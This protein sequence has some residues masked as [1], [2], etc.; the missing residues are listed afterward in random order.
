MTF[1]NNFGK[2]LVL[3]MRNNLMKNMKKLIILLLPFGQMLFGHGQHGY[4]DY[5]TDFQQGSEHTHTHH[6]EGDFTDSDNDG[7]TDVAEVKYGYNPNSASSFPLIDFVAESD[8][9]DTSTPVSNYGFANLRVH[10]TDG[11]IELT[12]NDVDDSYS[13]S[14]FSL[15]LFAGDKE[16]YYGGHGWDYA[17]VNY[18]LFGLNGTETLNGFL[19]ESNPSNGAYV[20]THTNFEIDLNDYP[21][22]ATKF[23]DPSNKITFK[24]VNFTTEQTNKYTD[25]MRRVIPILNDVL[26]VPSENF[27]CE[28]IMQSDEGNS[29]VTMNHGREIYLDA[30]WNPRLLVHEMVHMWEGKLGFSWS[31]FNR[32]Y[33]DDLSAFAEVAEG[34]A[35]RVLHDYIMAY[36]EHYVS[37][38]IANG[39]P[40]NNWSSD[41]WTYDLYKHKR[42]TGGGA[43]WT[44][45]LRSVNHRYSISAM[46]MQIILVQDP[47][48]IKNMRK[49]LFD[50]V[51]ADNHILSREE[52]VNLW[53]SNIE[54]INGID[55]ADY[56]NA[57]PVFN[58][59]KL[60]QGFYPVVNIISPAEVDIFSSYVTDGMFWWSYVVPDNSVEVQY[61]SIPISSLNVPSWVKY[62]YN[63]YDGYYYVDMNDIPFTFSI[64]NIKNEVLSAVDL[65]SSNGYQ[66]EGIIPDH[67]GEIRVTDQ[68]EVAPESFTQGLYKYNVTYTEVIKHTNEG[69]EDFYFMG[70]KDMPQSEGEMVLMFGVDSM[71]AEK[72]KV[73]GENLSVELEVVNGCA[74]LKTSDIPLNK[75]MMLTLSV[76]SLDETHV[77]KRALVHAGNSWG[78]YRQQFLIIDRDFDGVED[79]YDNSVSETDITNKYN[80][81]KD[82]HT[83]GGG[84][85]GGGDNG[86]G[87]DSNNGED[88]DFLLL[89]DWDTAELVG[90]N[91]KHLDWFGYFY[92]S[93]INPKWMYHVEL[94]WLYVP[95]DSFDSIW[96]YSEKFG[97]IWTTSEFFPFVYIRDKGWVYFNFDQGKYYDFTKKQYVTLQ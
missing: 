32:E 54:T 35:Y 36:P 79:L 4:A 64:K 15:A 86:G 71:F 56:L 30:N 48:F 38:D 59:K 49:D 72:V 93:A 89:N 78:E 92:Q 10:Q 23:G 26:G 7:M 83:N 95:G 75:E 11:G 42:F 63:P 70:E 76:S 57:M 39:G 88:D 41:A 60:D 58:G 77:Y 20:N 8:G 91:W 14:R 46:L 31:G 45:D 97:W 51:N 82:K 9:E 13:W 52:I 43:Y 81:Y 24:F 87:D 27:T 65:R 68:Y 2:V 67:L 61:G 55:T 80:A 29:W 47:D 12:W 96:M 5:G 1:Y 22:T 74:V 16:L 40:W 18:E 73:Q 21:V 25:F 17:D 28:F 34:T 66:D 3:R 62:N 44:G 33:S 50:I 90:N 53:A 19:M 94:G 6:Y 85:N 69:T 84:D 37:V